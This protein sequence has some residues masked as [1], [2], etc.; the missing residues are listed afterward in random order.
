MEKVVDGK[1]EETKALTDTERQ[2]V[3]RV[4]LSSTRL[5]NVPFNF[6]RLFG[7]IRCKNLF[8]FV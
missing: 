6:A 1:S 8:D 4:S 7:F 3:F 2:G 5:R